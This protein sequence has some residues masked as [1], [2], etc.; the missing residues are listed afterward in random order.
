MEKKIKEK[1]YV[2]IRAVDDSEEMIVEGYAAVFDSVT[3]LGWINEV[4]DK[5]A[6]NE[7]NMSDVCMKYNHEDSMLILARTRNKSLQLTVDDKGLK[8]RAKLIDTQNNRDIYKMIQAKLLDKMSF[9]FSVGK[10]SM[11]YDTDTRRILRIDKLYDVSI[12]DVP[13]YDNTEIYARSKIQYEEDKKQY[14]EKKKAFNLK[15][16]KALAKLKLQ[17][18][19]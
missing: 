10:Q 1:R 13:A 6:F 12:V 2:E 5:D 9:A 8:V 7:C 4:I 3:D 16:K 18:E 11:D 15:K 14:I 19:F 17:N